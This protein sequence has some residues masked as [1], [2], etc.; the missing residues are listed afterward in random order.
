MVIFCTTFIE[1][2]HSIP[3]IIF[4]YYNMV[5]YAI[6]VF[7]FLSMTFRG[8]KNNKSWI[9]HLVETKLRRTSI[10]CYRLKKRKWMNTDNN[11]RSTDRKH[12]LHC[13]HSPTTTTAHSHTN[14]IMLCHCF[15]S[16]WHI[17][18]T[19]IDGWMNECEECECKSS[20]T[21]RVHVH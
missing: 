4:S 17:V 5:F 21:C 2:I 1:C 7:F 10:F 20:E 11:H 3:T 9:K 6:F 19:S 13:T 12:I 18:R 15:T 8:D 16:I 14:K